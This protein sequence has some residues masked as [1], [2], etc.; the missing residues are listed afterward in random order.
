MQMLKLSR[1]RKR[2]FGE[3]L[4]FLIRPPHAM[5]FTQSPVRLPD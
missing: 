1:K 5:A 2:L 3:A 4:S